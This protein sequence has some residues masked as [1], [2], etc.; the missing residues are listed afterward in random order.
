[1]ITWQEGTII[2]LLLGAIIGSFFPKVLP[3]DLVWFSAAALTAVLGIVPA[4]ELLSSIVNPP[5]LTVACVGAFIRT[6]KSRS[7]SFKGVFLAIPW[8]L[9][10]FIASAFIFAAAIQQTGLVQNIKSAF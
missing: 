7:L 6:V 3:R 5:V 9:V 4:K 10:L 1:M 2:A 8:P